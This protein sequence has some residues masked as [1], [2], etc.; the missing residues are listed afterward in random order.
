MENGALW[1][2]LLT[3]ATAVVA[4]W[5]TSKGNAQAARI[6]AQAAA[7][8]AHVARKGEARRAT[9]LDFIQQANDMGILY[10]RIPKYLKVEDREARLASLGELRDQ[11]RDSYGPFLRCLAIVSL[12]CH[13]GPIEAAKAVHMASAEAYGRLVAVEE[14]IR[15]A[16]GFR[17]GVD[18]YLASVDSFVE[19]ARQ[20][21]REM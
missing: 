18:T 21:E 10:R 9:Q 6:Q 2:A 20:A 16:E 19:A 15:E 3:A 8:A 7:E 13:P 11:L 4:S 17:Q 1:V 12:E 14:D 5:V